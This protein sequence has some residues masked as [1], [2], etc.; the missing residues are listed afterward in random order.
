MKP[1]DRTIPFIETHHHLWE[2]GR[3]RYEWL[4]D[5]GYPGHNALLGDYKMIR[6]TIGSPRRFFREFYGANVTKSVHVEGDSSAPDP[7]QET[8][9]LDGV[10]KEFGF[11]NALVVFT[12][13]EKAGAEGELERHLAASS[14]VRGVRI[15]QHPADPFDRIFLV[16][17]R[18]LGRL[19]LSY[20]L[21]AS[22][23]QLLSGLALAKAEPAT[24]VILGHAGFPVQRDPEYFALWKREMSELAAAENVS[25][26]VSGLG[27]A[28]NTWTVDSLRPY[29]L[30]CIEAFGPDRVM[31]GTNW[32]VDIL[33]ATYLETVDAYR[34]IIAEAGFDRIEQAKMLSG[35][36]E[37]LYAL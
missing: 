14:L 22:P 33:F 15:R 8:V 37:R 7:V 34:A 36:A 28:D 24:R 16:A 11:P 2:L 29:V 9:W 31:F 27:M 26:K 19:G 3:F 25:C 20:E 23:G 13:M 18:A 12:D 1:V 17:Y 4:Q 32:P 5:P 30:H 21:N 35:N 10:A 6:S